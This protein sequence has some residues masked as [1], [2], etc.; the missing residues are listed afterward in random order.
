MACA[1]CGLESMDGTY[2]RIAALDVCE[3]CRTSGVFHHLRERAYEAQNRVW[4][5][6]S[7]DIKKQYQ[8]I[9]IR[10]PVDTG[11][12]LR[13]VRERWYHDLTRLFRREL[14][15]GD[16]LFDEYIYVAKGS[17]A[18][19]AT[20]LANEGVQSAILLVGVQGT[21]T[22]TRSV[23]EAHFAS[24]VGASPEERQARVLEVAGAAL[25]IVRWHEERQGSA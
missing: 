6:R 7:G 9:T 13:C 5:S 16:P 22:L 20:L 17:S 10:L 23:L 21:F 15:V 3:E 25:H 1:F 2:A 4:V 19:V 14:E 12:R 11:I 18:D 8:R 24:T